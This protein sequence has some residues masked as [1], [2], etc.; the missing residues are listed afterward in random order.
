M[1]GATSFKSIDPSSS[2]EDIV[3]TNKKTKK[4]RITV[5]AAGSFSYCLKNNALWPSLLPPPQGS[6]CPGVDL[7][8]SALLAAGCIEVG[9]PPCDLP[10]YLY[11]TSCSSVSPPSPPLTLFS[12]SSGLVP[13]N[14]QCPLVQYT[15]YPG[16]KNGCW[17]L[18]CC[19]PHPPSDLGDTH[20]G[21]TALTS[22][23]S[24]F[25][26]SYIYIQNTKWPK[27]MFWKKGIIQFIFIFIISIAAYEEDK[28]GGC[29]WRRTTK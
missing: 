9:G 25:W 29:I 8:Q 13:Q 12:C 7:L 28:G 2:T 27:K 24:Y 11:P 17:W 18:S 14:T 22:P 21:I 3:E 20:C 6:S 16:G 19:I 15:V 4:T 1:L 5:K 26:V 10:N 23:H